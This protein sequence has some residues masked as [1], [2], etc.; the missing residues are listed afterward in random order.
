MKGAKQR[1]VLRAQLGL[2]IM[3]DGEQISAQRGKPELLEPEG[4]GLLRCT[5]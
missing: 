5:L 1:L 4:F 2:G 3:A